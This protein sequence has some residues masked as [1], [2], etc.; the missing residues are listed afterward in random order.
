MQQARSLVVPDADLVAGL[1]EGT[2]ADVEPAAAG[3]QQL[4]GLRMGAQEVNEALELLRVAGTDVGSLAQQVLRVR[5][6]AH[7]AVDVLVAE[8]G[9]D[10]DGPYQLSGRL[11]EHHAAVGHVHHVLQ[12][13]FVAR[14][15]LRVEK[16]LQKEVFRES[17]VIYWCFHDSCV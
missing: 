9:V 16:L 7:M 15:L 1:G 10:D 3:G 5:D 6:A 12:R 14:V 4:V 2:P 13:G 17:G 11:Q 8:T